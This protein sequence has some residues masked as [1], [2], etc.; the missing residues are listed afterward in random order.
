MADVRKM[1]IPLMLLDIGWRIAVPL[2]IL[3]LAGVYL[4]KYLHT[5]PLFLFVGIFLSLATSSFGVYKSIQN[6]YKVNK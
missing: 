5:S 6:I 2:V 4:D 1:N 3:V